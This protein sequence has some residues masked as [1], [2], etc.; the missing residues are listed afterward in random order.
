[1]KRV[2]DVAMATR[3]LRGTILDALKA[4]DLE[5]VG[6]STNRPD[7][8]DNLTSASVNLFLYHV[9]P[10]T[11]L[12]NLDAPV[13]RSDGR[14]LQRPRMALD[15]H[16]LVSFYGYNETS[17]EKLLGST[18]TYLYSRPLLS[19][20][21][22]RDAWDEVNGDA[23]VEDEEIRQYLEE[24]PRIALSLNQFSLEDLSKLW[25]VLFQVP[26]VLS[27]AYRATAVILEQEHQERDAPPVLEPRVRSR[28]GSPPR[29]DRVR[30]LGPLGTPLVMG[31]TL[32]IQGQYLSRAGARTVVR[33]DDTELEPIKETA[34]ELR[35]VLSPHALPDLGVGAHALTV[36][37]T[38]DHGAVDVLSAPVGMVMQP[39]LGLLV[40]DEEAS[41]LTVAPGSTL[42]V[43]IVPAV[44]PKAVRLVLRRE[45]DES[46]PL[47]APSIEL[48]PSTALPDPTT[49]LAFQLPALATGS[50]IVRAFV[51]RIGSPL[52][53]AES[54]A[55]RLLP[56]IQV[57]EA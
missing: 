33:I 15:L 29:I 31:S 28:V 22:I 27:V 38:D 12:R 3:A 55:P 49:E 11:S 32:L 39:K 44:V 50:Y 36:G 4:A 52:V 57:S 19:P 17:P 43:R 26:Y 1:M 34:T 5:S 53:R 56:R 40:D 14:L 45:A 6:V 2:F 51:G 7:K 8:A 13:R 25:S 54:G 47:G 10:N 23:P 30:P 41:E 16:Y 20:T 24:V 18:V 42:S 46:A 9:E 37:V 21:R 35:V 48:E